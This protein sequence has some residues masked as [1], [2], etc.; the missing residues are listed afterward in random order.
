MR[1]DVNGSTIGYDVYGEGETT[2]AL[3]HAFPLS[4]GQWR[5]QG[6][7]LAHALALRVVAPDLRGCGESGVADDEPITMERMA[8]DTLALLDALDARRIVLGGLSMGGYC[9]FAALRLAPERIAGVIL[10]DTRATPDTPEGRAGREATAAFVVA[11]GPGA[12]FDRDAPKLLSNRVLAR[13]PEIVANARALAEMSRA[14]G[15]AAQ[16]R[17]MALRPD[18]TR[19][20]PQITCP[21]LMLVGDQDAITPIADA[22]ALFERIPDAGLSVIEDAGHL[23]NLERPE[24]FTELAASFLREKLGIKDR[25]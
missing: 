24:L 16:A 10:A 14:E 23:S 22:R 12:L 11:Q 2:L 9:A 1:L 6:E 8:R 18:S 19:L 25:G 4:R 13:H 3:L 20:L 15:L 17:G 7:A 5:A 21:A